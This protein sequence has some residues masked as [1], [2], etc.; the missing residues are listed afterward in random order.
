V[1][2]QDIH[3]G[4]DSMLRARA[5]G[6]AA[7]TLVVASRLVWYTTDSNLTEAED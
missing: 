4:M 7:G 6:P 5:H 3:S 2:E 1:E